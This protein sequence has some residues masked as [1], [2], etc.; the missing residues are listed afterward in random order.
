MNTI[1]IVLL[2]ACVRFARPG[3]AASPPEDRV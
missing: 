2:A 1:E 3:P